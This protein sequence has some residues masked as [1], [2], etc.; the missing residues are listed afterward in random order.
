M[1]SD[2]EPQVHYIPGPEQETQVPVEQVHEPQEQL[3]LFSVLMHRMDSHIAMMAQAVQTAKES[4]PESSGIKVAPPEVFDRTISKSSDFITQLNLYFKGRKVKN[5]DDKI[6][7][8]LSYMKGGTVGPWVKDMAERFAAED[9]NWKIF[10]TNFKSSF[11]DPDPAGTAIRKMDLLKQGTHTVDEYVASFNELK[12]DTGFNDPALVDKFE[13]GLNQALVDKIYSLPD[14][15]TTLE[16]WIYWASKL[17]RQWRQREARKKMSAPAPTAPKQPSSSFKPFQPRVIQPSPVPAQIIP[18]KE[19]DVIPM[20]VDS[21]WKRVRSIVCYKC[22]R[23]GHIARNCPSGVDINSMDYDT[24]KAHI[25]AELENEG[26]LSK[27][28]DF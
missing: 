15:P 22:K 24:L 20:E 7:L 28:E 12:K 11:G 5:D 18:A 19:P 8:A 21:G 10:I 2:M 3:D 27:K 26:S 6:L 23:R 16:K 9:L 1:S 17:D 4:T 25:K 14:M 13:K